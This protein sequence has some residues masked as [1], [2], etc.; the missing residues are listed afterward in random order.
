MKNFRF[1]VAALAMGLALNSCS[2]DDDKSNNDA[3]IVGKWN[4]ATEKYYINN[5]LEYQ[6]PYEE[7]EP[8]CAPDF[9]QIFD[10]GSVD[11]GDYSGADCTLDISSGYY[12]RS[13]NTL[14]LVEDLGNMVTFEIVSVTS[15]TLVLKNTYEY[16]GD[17]EVSEIT[18][19]KAQ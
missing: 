15:N 8:G 5:N 10:A 13:G 9:L 2:S 18:F 3:S 16:D 19:S 4:F 7:N 11:Q 17:T 12:T 6:G 14:T 1:I